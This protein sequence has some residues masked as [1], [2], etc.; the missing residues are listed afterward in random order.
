MMNFTSDKHFD[1]LDQ[2]GLETNTAIR[3]EE[4]SNEVIPTSHEISI[5]GHFVDGDN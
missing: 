3:E 5:R 2:R 1:L 4:A